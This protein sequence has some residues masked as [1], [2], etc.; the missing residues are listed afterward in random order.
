[1]TE[2]CAE[3]AEEI[4]P[5][6]SDEHLRVLVGGEEN[7]TIFSH[8]ENRRS[9]DDEDIVGQIE[10]RLDAGLCCDR[11]RPEIRE[12]A[13]H[14][15]DAVRAGNQRPP[16]HRGKI[17]DETRSSGCR[18]TRRENGAR[19]EEQ[20]HGYFSPSIS[21]ISRPCLASSSIHSLIC[22][23]EK[24]RGSGMK[25]PSLRSSAVSLMA[26]SSRSLGGSDFAAA[27][28]SASVLIAWRLALVI[29]HSQ[30]TIPSLE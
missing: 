7:R 9:V 16:I 2:T 21:R 11:V 24:A 5:V 26:S 23:F 4:L 17:H 1:M 6:E 8:R 3:C 20:P 12:V 10:P 28:I 14:F 15:G 30:A 13:S 25:V 19:I 29:H 27:S 18:I 22:S